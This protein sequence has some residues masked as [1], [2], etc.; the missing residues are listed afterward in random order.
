MSNAVISG[1]GVFTPPHV[2]TNEE[3]VQSYNNYADRY[4]AEN[5]EAIKSGKIESLQ[6]STCE[7][8]EKASGIKQR[9]VMIKEGILD[10]DRMMPLI[11]RR[12]TDSL[13][14]TAEMSIAAARMALSR[15][16]RSLRI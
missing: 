4:N 1:S 2:V 10:V 16:T 5:T 11:P 14:I 9:Y 12:P 15:Q 3:L 13:S 7:F 8:I 6:Y